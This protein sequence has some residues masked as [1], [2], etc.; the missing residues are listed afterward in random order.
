MQTRCQCVACSGN[1]KVFA[2]SCVVLCACVIGMDSRTGC[3]FAINDAR[4]G[5]AGCLHRGPCQPCSAPA[6][7]PGDPN[8]LAHFLTSTARSESSAGDRT[9]LPVAGLKTSRLHRLQAACKSHSSQ[10]DPTGLHHSF[11]HSQNSKRNLVWEHNFIYGAGG[12]T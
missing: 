1:L 12:F 6:A 10:S 8:L 5:A 2:A 7:R 4:C 3:S 11:L 9:H